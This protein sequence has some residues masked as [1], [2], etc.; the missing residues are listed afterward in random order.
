MTKKIVAVLYDPKTC[1]TVRYVQE[2]TDEATEVGTE[3]LWTEGNFACDCN[4]SAFMYPG[5]SYEDHYACGDT[6]QLKH[7]WFDVVKIV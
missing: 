4:R 6:I 3:F 1:K 2:A 5:L 7:L